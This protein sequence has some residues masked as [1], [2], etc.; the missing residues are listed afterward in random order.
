MGGAGGRR[1]GL[2]APIQSG[3]SLRQFLHVWPHMHATRTTCVKT[4]WRIVLENERYSH[5]ELRKR[6][7]LHEHRQPATS[8]LPCSLLAQSMYP[9]SSCFFS[10]VSDREKVAKVATVARNAE[11]Q[12]FRG[13]SRL[14]TFDSSLFHLQRGPALV[15]NIDSHDDPFLLPL[16]K[17]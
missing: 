10:T 12:C 14:P 4:K 16:Q 5:F 2:D 9:L 6:L 7:E 8:Q 15:T 11:C 13:W 1:V 3:H 17:R